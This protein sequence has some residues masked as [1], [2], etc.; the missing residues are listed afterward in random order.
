M[1]WNLKQH[2]LTQGPSAFLLST[3]SVLLQTWELPQDQKMAAGAPA[4]KSI[5]QEERMNGQGAKLM[6][7][8]TLFHRSHGRGKERR[9]QGRTKFSSL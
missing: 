6:Q 4:I 1:H 5:S 3:L 2:S 8:N 9:K 7:V